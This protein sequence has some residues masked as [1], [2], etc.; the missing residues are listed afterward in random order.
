MIY[1]E[2]YSTSQ[3][4][5]SEWPNKVK[6]YKIIPSSNKRLFNTP[7]WYVFSAIMLISALVVLNGEL[8]SDMKLS[9]TSN[10]GIV[11]LVFAILATVAYSVAAA[12]IIKGALVA[13]TGPMKEQSTTK[14]ENITQSEDKSA[15]ATPW[16]TFPLSLLLRT[17]FLL[18]RD[19]IRGHKWSLCCGWLVGTRIVLS[20][21]LYLSGILNVHG[22]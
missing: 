19:L 13:K 4:T 9:E 17:W 21:T 22:I 14:D 3:K 7:S 5:I 11:S 8:T 18:N 2:F 16:Y 10:L 6:V 1:P 12:F 20:F 15:E